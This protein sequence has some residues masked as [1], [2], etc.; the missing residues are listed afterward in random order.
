MRRENTAGGGAECLPTPKDVKINHIWSFVELLKTYFIVLSEEVV[1]IT[2][3][4]FSIF[5]SSRDILDSQKNNDFFS[6][7][8]GL[9]KQWNNDTGRRLF[10][11]FMCI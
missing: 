9:I 4:S 6:N 1:K 3:D 7:T 5:F 10:R 2:L 11:N 8:V